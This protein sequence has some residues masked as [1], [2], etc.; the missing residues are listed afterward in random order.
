MEQK[1][2][3]N[4]ENAHNMTNTAKGR[5]MVHFVRKIKS[6]EQTAEGV[7]GDY[8]RYKGVELK[9]ELLWKNV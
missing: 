2:E 4:D 6:V 7:R 8:L 1:C 9:A 3:Q 5:V